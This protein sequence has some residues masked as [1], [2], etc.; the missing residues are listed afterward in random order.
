MMLK[1]CSRYQLFIRDQSGGSLS[2]RKAH[3]SFCLYLVL[4]SCSEDKRLGFLN[5][6]GEI[7]HVIK[8]AHS[9]PINRCEFVD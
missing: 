3:V 2:T 7:A 1:D 4:A 5:A 6:E 9:N 8:K